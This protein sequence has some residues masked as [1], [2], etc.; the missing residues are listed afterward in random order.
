MPARKKRR[1]PGFFRRLAASSLASSKSRPLRFQALES[2]QLLAGDVGEP[3]ADITGLWVT[4]GNREYFTSEQASVTIDMIA[5]E[6]LQ[7]TGI[8]YGL[9]EDR[10]GR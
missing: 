8:R 9:D 10:H 3:L 2:R 6:T 5:G 4:V 1:R 7:V